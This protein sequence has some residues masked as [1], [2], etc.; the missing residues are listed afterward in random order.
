MKN[1]DIVNLVIDGTER[2]A[3]VVKT[4]EDIDQPYVDL[5]ELNSGVLYQSVL[6]ESKVGDGSIRHFTKKT[7]AEQKEV[8]AEQEAKVEDPAPGGKPARSAPGGK[9][10]T[11]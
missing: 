3:E 5:R 2:D 9:P 7:A 8:R 1:G 4:Y 11:A 6:E 10:E